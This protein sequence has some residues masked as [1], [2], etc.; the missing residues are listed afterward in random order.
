MFLS[1]VPTTSWSESG[2][3][4]HWL[5]RSSLVRHFAHGA[6]AHV[7]TR[8]AFAD[9]ADDLYSL[10]V[11]IEPLHQFILIRVRRR[12]LVTVILDELPQIFNVLKD[13][14]S[15]VGPRPQLVSFGKY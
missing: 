11:L 5:I 4:S 3:P 15:L 13:E 7:A 8:Q 6:D 10:A 14:M 9:G 12:W 2:G 1:C